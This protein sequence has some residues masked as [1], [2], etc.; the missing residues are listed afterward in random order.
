VDLSVESAS[1]AALE[2]VYQVLDANVD[3][4]TVQMGSDSSASVSL[5]VKDDLAK[6][7]GAGWRKSLISLSC[8]ADQGLRI[9]S[10]TEPLIISADGALTLQL[11]T[12]QIV[13]NP[14]GANCQL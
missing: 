14:G 9:E 11:A 5:D 8:F 2:L 1:G 10:V 3:S 6:N 13:A 7:V 12:V 4:V